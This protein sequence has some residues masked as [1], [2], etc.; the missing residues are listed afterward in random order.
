MRGARVHEHQPA[1]GLALV[2]RWCN[3]GDP[4][5]QESVGPRLPFVA[6]P[7]GAAEQHNPQLGAHDQLGQWMGFESVGHVR[8]QLDPVS[9]G[10]AMCID[11]V[12]GEREPDRQTAGPTGELITEV[13]RVVGI[14]ARAQHID[15]RTV[16]GVDVASER[17]LAIDE[18]AR[19][20]CSEQPLVRIDDERVGTT[21]PDKPVA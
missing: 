10:R 14:V 16:L 9:D 13:A 5:F 4:A 8:G 2:G 3:E 20:R 7:A 21:Q 17:G 1:D 15:V 11:A 6:A 19:A 12:E 18:R